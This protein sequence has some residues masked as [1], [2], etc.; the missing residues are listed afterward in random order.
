MLLRF[1]C[2]TWGLALRP[3]EGFYHPDEDK[4]WVSTI[5]FPGN[6][7]SNDN[8]IYG[9]ALQ[10]AVG[11]VLMPARVL[12]LT[13]HPLVRGVT[14]EQL[15][16]LVMRTFHASLGAL[17]VLLV[18]RLGVRLFGRMT[19]LLA[20]AILSV[21]L[22][23]VINSPLASLD[24]PMGF[25][26]TLDVLLAARAFASRRPRDF[27][28]L[29]LGMGVL[30]A[31]RISG[32]LIVAV[33]AVL[34]AATARERGAGQPLSDAAGARAASRPGPKPR[35]A[36]RSHEEVTRG[37]PRTLPIATAVALSLAIATAV[38]VISTPHVVVHLTR[39]L[40][41]MADV[42]RMWFYRYS[43]D[44]L[45]IL[46]ARVRETSTVM[47][48]LVAALVPAGLAVALASRRGERRP[49]LW[50][51]LAFLA[52]D[53]LLW[54]GFLETRYILPTVPLL[55]VLAALPLA[56]LLEARQRA[57]RV[58]GGLLAALAVGY[59]AEQCLLGITQRFSDT[60]T[61]AARYIAEHVP[62][63]ASLALAPT[64]E[65]DPWDE[66][67]WRYPA[68]SPSRQA[69]LTS[70]FSR[71]RYIVTSSYALGEIEQ[72]LR[73]DE[74][75]PGYQW[76]ATKAGRWYKYRVPTP[77]ELRFFD[78]LLSG[79]AGYVEERRWVPSPEAR[80]NFPAPQIRLY[81]R[82]GS[83]LS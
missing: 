17:A 72:A 1:A 32:V 56:R 37:A 41:F 64:T 77:D 35:H 78:E 36:S 49:L 23:H 63:H 57:T 14:Y 52:A 33:P 40:D 47:T 21:S 53:V 29:G 60:R 31:T 4:A 54:R 11:T 75:R 25:L 27:V 80:I 73:S 19:G 82:T 45:G 50:A 55:A 62:A 16:G 10:Y 39:Y 58:A 13:G 28:L 70:T 59:S 18:H 66:H 6:Y 38:F 68:L 3:Y 7:F 2:L 71:P 8:Y 44:P 79:A 67:P 9:T 5:E 65:Q 81:R 24:V 46:R 83:G 69:R 15:V 74:I 22:Y 12:W 42:H 48:P 20:A 76:P 30:F 34:A 43:H 26:V 61:A 51:V